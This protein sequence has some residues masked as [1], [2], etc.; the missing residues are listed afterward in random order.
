M[1]A[2]AQVKLEVLG[3]LAQVKAECLSPPHAHEDA[4]SSLADLALPA[5]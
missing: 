2:L 3:V 5:L 4:G 1:E